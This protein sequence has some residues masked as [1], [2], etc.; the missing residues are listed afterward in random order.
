MASE[1][2]QAR[3]VPAAEYAISAQCSR[4]Q[5]IRRIQTGEVKG[6]LERGRWFVYEA[7]PERE[8]APSAA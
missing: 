3:R 4:E 2:G 1:N 6:G 7:A 8:P 5:I